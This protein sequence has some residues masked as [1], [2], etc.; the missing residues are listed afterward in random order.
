M[1]LRFDLADALVASLPA[2]IA[3][4]DGPR[5]AEAL[6]RVKAVRGFLDSYEARLTSHIARLHSQGESAPAADLHTRNGGV[7]SKEARQ[8]ERRAKALESSPSLADKLAIGDVTAGHADV[9]ADVTA[10]LDDDTKR[11][12]F[13]HESDVAD[14]AARLSPEDFRTSCRDLI[15]QIERDQGIERDR[16][17]R[18]DTRLSKRVD[19]DGMYILNARLHPELGTAVFNSLDAETAK[20]VKAGADRTVDRQQLAADALG[21][22]VIGGHQAVRPREAEIRLHVDAETLVDGPHPGGICE[23]ADGTPVPPA[24]ARRLICNGRI[25]PIV[26]DTDGVVLN[27]GREIR[28]ANRA[29]RRALRAMYRSCA[30]PGCDVKFDNCEVHHV[31]PYELGG[32]TNLDELVPLCSRHHHV[33]HEPGWHLTLDHDRTLTVHQPDGTVYATSPLR[34]GATRTDQRRTTSGNAPAPDRNDESGSG[35]Q[36]DAHEGGLLDGRDRPHTTDANPPDRPDRPHTTEADPPEGREPRCSTPTGATDDEG[37]PGHPG[38]SMSYRGRRLE[39][40][41][42]SPPS[43]PAD[44]LTLI[45]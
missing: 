30:F 29:Q 23:Y 7:S 20:L 32:L 37:P 15:A 45:A 39:P 12:F 24:T 10:R 5:A 8:K 38:T 1:E 11:Q 43:D 16:Q 34:T 17:R 9:V 22:L 2:D 31:N 42:A 6:G 27:A 4:L 13:D 18:R 40:R 44:Q 3:A 33:V 36:A 35:R 21:N 19:G 14:D 26:I 25:I 28:V 41:G